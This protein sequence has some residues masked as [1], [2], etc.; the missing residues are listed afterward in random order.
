MPR[1]LPVL[2]VCLS[3]Q[4][5]A[6]ILNMFAA[7][8]TAA[9]GIA[10]AGAETLTG[11]PVSEVV[12]A[13]ESL[14]SL[15]RVIAENPGAANREELLALREHFVEEAEIASKTTPQG[16]ISTLRVDRRRPKD[17]RP[18]VLK[19]TYDKD[20]NLIKIEAGDGSRGF[21][22]SSEPPDPFAWKS[23]SRDSWRFTQ[24]RRYQLGRQVPPGPSAGLRPLLKNGAND[25]SAINRQ[26]GNP[27]PSSGQ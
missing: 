21:Q 22:V 16:H 4:S 20:G 11:A 19:S 8:E 10:V 15:D 18:S 5:C 27:L 14:S 3:L 2:V 24:P 12:G 23:W 9:G 6:T 26:G 17:E 1:L 13:S 25:F 7:P